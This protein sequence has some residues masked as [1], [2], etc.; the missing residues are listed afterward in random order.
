MRTK[1]TARSGRNASTKPDADTS[2][3][4]AQTAPKSLDKATDSADRLAYL[5]K[6]YNATY[7]RTNEDG[8]VRIVLHV[9]GE[10]AT[11]DEAIASLISQLGAE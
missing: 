8:K 7:S 3:A 5:S 1:G 11:N 4:P 10:G 6:K 9:T 2:E